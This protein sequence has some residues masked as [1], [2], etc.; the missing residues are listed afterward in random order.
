M[1]T[2]AVKRESR[3]KLII[4]VIKKRE[5]KMLQDLTRRGCKLGF[6]KCNLLLSHLQYSTYYLYFLPLFLSYPLSFSLIIS[7]R[8]LRTLITRWL[9]FARMLKKSFDNISQLRCI[10]LRHLPVRFESEEHHSKN[11]RS[12]EAN[13]HCFRLNIFADFFAGRN[14]FYVT[15]VRS[16]YIRRQTRLRNALIADKWGCLKQWN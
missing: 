12:N 3:D 4:F 13:L 2:V 9:R 1:E 6:S 5:E 11:G 7:T 10:F 15:D 8:S 16:Q 14:Y